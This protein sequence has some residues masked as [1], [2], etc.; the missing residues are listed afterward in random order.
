MKMNSPSFVHLDVNTQYSLG[1]S[2]IR[3]DQL[4]DACIDMNMPAF[5]VTDHK[6]FSLH[7]SSISL[8][9]RKA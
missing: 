9:K 6:T 3:Q 8:L 2:I 7:I 5:G 1:R 4:I